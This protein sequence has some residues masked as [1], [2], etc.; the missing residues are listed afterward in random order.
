MAKR[1]KPSA[2]LSVRVDAPLNR[3]LARESRRTGRTK[4]EVA[5]E[6]L[7]R[8]L[9]D[10]EGEALAT[11]ARRQSLLVRDRESEADALHFVSDVAD[12]RGW[13]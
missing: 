10:H 5:R 12:L 9:L 6:I 7:E 4:S 1:D 11:R 2:V 13:K 8:A 3:E